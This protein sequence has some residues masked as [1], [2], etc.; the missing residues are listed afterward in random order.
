MHRMVSLTGVGLAGVVIGGACPMAA[1]QATTRALWVANN[2][3][4][5]GSV[6]C[7]QVNPDD[8]LTFVE[9]EI[10][11]T[12][13]LAIGVSPHGR[14]LATGRAGGEEVS[15]ELRIFR[16]NADAS[17]DLLHVELLPKT[18]FSLEWVDP[19]VVA[20][21]ET[22]LD[23]GRYN[24][25]TYRFDEG[26]S[27]RGGGPSV[28]LID[29]GVVG[30]FNTATA[31]DRL[32]R[33]LYVNNSSS[34]TIH[35]F[36]VEADGSLTEG[37]VSGSPV[38]PLNIVLTPDGTRM[39]AGG[40]ISGG[41]DKIAGWSSTGG[42]GL[43]A[44]PGSPFLSQGASPAFPSTARDGEFLFVGHG[45]DGTVRGFAIDAGTGA[46]TDINELFDVGTQGTVGSLNH[47][48]DLLFIT[49]KST[50]GDGMYGV[51]VFEVQADGALVQVG[52]K[53]DP[54]G[55]APTNM[56]VWDPAS[57]CAGDLNGDGATD[58]ADLSVLVGS[59]GQ[60]V[61]PGTSGD[62]NGDGVVDSADLSVL[63]GDFGCAV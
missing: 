53:Y 13:Q 55:V 21:T 58:S 35:A 22:N 59:F 62:V 30:G 28:T 17:L 10:T 26:A 5:D 63:V 38:F 14:Y 3:N 16:V 18:P 39:Y 11:N 49:D 45:T 2:G 23:A 43:L 50:F 1:G 27:L 42:G 8:T 25:R 6:T 60:A 34:D 37:P 54:Q 51:L 31:Y 33:T 9:R 29:T 24:I 41:G 32:T 4:I 56:A 36:T 48:G 40:G 7:Y 12:N 57:G 20:V 61:P 52:P 46:L 19:D 47:L 15:D 44:I